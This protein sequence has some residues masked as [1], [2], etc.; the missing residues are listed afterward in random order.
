MLLGDPKDVQIKQTDQSLTFAHTII[1]MNFG[2]GTMAHIEYTVTDQEQI[3]L[4]WSGIKNIIEFDSEEVGVIQSGTKGIST[5]VYTVDAILATAH[6][7]DQTLVDR[8]NHFNKLI[9]GGA[10]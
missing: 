6:Q 2:G 7:L 5:L 3:E 9:K 1:M 4:E 10:N 8:L